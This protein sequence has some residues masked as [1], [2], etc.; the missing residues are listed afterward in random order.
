MNDL[1]YPWFSRTTGRWTSERRYIF[2]MKKKKPTN[3]STSFTIGAAT[4]GQYDYI[5][6]WTGQT[7][8]TMNLKLIGTELHRDIG[9]YTDKPTVSQ[10]SMIDPDTLLMVTSYDGM[11]FREEVRLLYNDTVRLRQTIGC[12]ISDG[13]V[14]I[15]GQYYE[16]REF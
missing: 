14:R 2:D 6:E 5:V 12:A 8:G 7:K 16:T 3:M 4:D 10:L 11:T 9:Y 15:V 13:T 1:I